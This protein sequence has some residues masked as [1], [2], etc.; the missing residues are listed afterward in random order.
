MKYLLLVLALALSACD[1]M[2]LDGSYVKDKRGN[3]YLLKS[4]ICDTYLL[5]PIDAKS[6]NSLNDF[7]N[8]DSAE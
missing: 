4:R 8:G 5:Q 7:V 6:V 2:E 1:L 3:V